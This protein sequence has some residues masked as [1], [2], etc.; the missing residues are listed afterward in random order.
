VS[1]GLDNAH[2]APQDSYTGD[3]RLFFTGIS[4]ANK[5]TKYSKQYLKEKLSY[6]NVSPKE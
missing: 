3:K 2:G 6:S 5:G 1:F 4:T